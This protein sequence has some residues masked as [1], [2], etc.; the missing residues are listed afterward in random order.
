MDKISELMDGELPLRESKRQIERLEH[1]AELATGWNTYHL[2]RD[3]LRQDVELSPEFARRVHECLEREPT[4]IAP[5]TRISH[6]LVRYSLPMAAGVAGVALVAWL[7]LSVQ[8]PGGAPA[9]QARL[10]VPPAA[11]AAVNDYM[12]A[13]QEFSPSTAMQGVASYVRTVSAH[14]ADPAR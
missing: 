9:P 12:L 2:I 13:H 14:E 8:M 7:A 4:V 3:A 5:Y 1:D 11:P 6:R 10:Q